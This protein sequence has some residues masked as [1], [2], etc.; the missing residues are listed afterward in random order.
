[1]GTVKEDFQKDGM[2]GLDC[3]MSYCDK[4]GMDRMSR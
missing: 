3:Q 1:V 4:S 2:E